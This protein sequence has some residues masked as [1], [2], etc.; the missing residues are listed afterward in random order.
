MSSWG[1][2]A[3]AW[4]Q[5]A[6]WGHSW[7]SPSSGSDAG[8]HAA[9]PAGGGGGRAT[10]KRTGTGRGKPLPP[11]GPSSFVGPQGPPGQCISLVWPETI[12]HS[13][14]PKD[15]KWSLQWL[16]QQAELVGCVIRIRGR[17]EPTILMHMLRGVVYVVWCSDVMQCGPST[18]VRVSVGAQSAR[19]HVSQNLVGPQERTRRN[20]I[21]L[22]IFGPHAHVEEV[23]ELVIKAAAGHSQRACGTACGMA[24]HA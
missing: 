18:H 9:T 4:W 19:N 3:G 24:W 13:F 22:T 16:N 5:G 21:H 15:Q 20:P 6:W 17:L 11:G 12:V 23:L 10:P 1:G 14:L 2:S 8:W 7:G